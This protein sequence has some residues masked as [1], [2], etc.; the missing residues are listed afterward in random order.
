MIL[1]VRVYA[2]AWK[3]IISGKIVQ[4]TNYNINMKIILLSGGSGQ[5]LWPL[6]NGAQAKQFLRL[7]KSPDGEKESMVQRVVRQI[8]EAGLLE[9]ITVATSAAQADMI[10][11][12]LSEYG[13]F[14]KRRNCF[15]AATLSQPLHLQ[16]HISKK[17][18]IAQPTKRWW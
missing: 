13:D 16:Q 6:S 14:S 1:C 3:K 18:S 10:S 7:L 15:P 9:S 12:Q 17:K 8:K 11:N 2:H 4:Q 5:R